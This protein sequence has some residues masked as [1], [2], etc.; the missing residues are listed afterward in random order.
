M[1]NDSWNWIHLHWI[2]FD[3][4]ERR[5]ETDQRQIS[6]DDKLDQIFLIEYLNQINKH[7]KK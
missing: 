4:F 5:V 6:I 3:R 7:P 1:M 2:R